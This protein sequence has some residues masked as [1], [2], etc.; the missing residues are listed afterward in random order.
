MYPWFWIFAPQIHL[1]FSGGVQQDID[2][3]SNWSGLPPP[4]LGSRQRDWLPYLQA[5]DT[6]IGYHGIQPQPSWGPDQMAA[7]DR[8]KQWRD[9]LGQAGERVLQPPAMPDSPDGFIAASPPPPG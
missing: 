7:L 9:S 2:P 1:P 4:S 6:L 5:L 8:L 3:S